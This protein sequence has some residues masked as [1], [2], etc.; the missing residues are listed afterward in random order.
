MLIEMR[1]KAGVRQVELAQKL[2][3]P[4]SF[5]SKYENGERRLDL[6]ELREVCLAL[7]ITLDEFVAEFEHVLFLRRANNTDNTSKDPH[8]HE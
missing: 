2:N 5:V 4:Q 7:N 1:E 6:T 3:K 8:K